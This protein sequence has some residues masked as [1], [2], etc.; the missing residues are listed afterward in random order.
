MP[1]PPFNNDNDYYY[2]QNYAVVKGYS[3]MRKNI[4]SAARPPPPFRGEA[5][6]AGWP[7]HGTDVAVGHAQRRA[8]G[9]WFAFPGGGGRRALAARRVMQEGAGDGGPAGGCR[10]GLSAIS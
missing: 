6:R 1:G 5:A 9:G 10:A 3:G 2:S 4:F 7:R 8:P